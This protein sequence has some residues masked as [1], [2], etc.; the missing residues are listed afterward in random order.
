ML[1]GDEAHVESRSDHKGSMEMMAWH[2]SSE[3]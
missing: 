1:G 3:K 2:M